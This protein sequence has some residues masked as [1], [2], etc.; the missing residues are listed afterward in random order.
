V[1]LFKVLFFLGFLGGLIGLIFTEEGVTVKA[2][3]VS[4]IARA[5]AE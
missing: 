2:V 3:I 5:F 4:W 1:S